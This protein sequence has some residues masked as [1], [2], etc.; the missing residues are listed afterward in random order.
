MHISYAQDAKVNYLYRCNETLVQIIMEDLFTPP[1][2]SRVQ[3]YPNIAAYEVLCYKDTK[4]HS[5]A[6]QLKDLSRIS[7]PE[8]KVDLSLASMIAFTTVA[9]KLVYSEY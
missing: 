3:M 5:L 9:R 7:A 4:L 2:A 8:N 1:V 6:G